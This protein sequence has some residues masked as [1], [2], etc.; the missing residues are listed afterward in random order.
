V[1]DERAGLPVPGWWNVGVEY[2]DRSD[3]DRQELEDRLDA[4]MEALV[5]SEG[6]ALV[7]SGLS[8]DFAARTVLVE[9]GVRAA[10][11]RAAVAA[12]REAV[13]A[14]AGRVGWCS[15]LDVAGPATVEDF[16]VV[17]REGGAGA[18]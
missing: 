18:G 9:L 13:A 1:A 12:H 11:E 16:E 4:L 6:P 3:A 14:A 5:D 10:G 15:L 17:H 8:A 7:D 2:T